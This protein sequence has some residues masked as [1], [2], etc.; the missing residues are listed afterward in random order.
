M[1]VFITMGGLT[2]YYLGGVNNEFY[3]VYHSG[4]SV[5]TL[6]LGWSQQ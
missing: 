2:K 5:V 4:W 3:S 1:N 6:I